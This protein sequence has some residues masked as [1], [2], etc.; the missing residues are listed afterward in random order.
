MREHWLGTWATGLMI[1]SMA[2]VWRV[3]LGWL[4]ATDAPTADSGHRGRPRVAA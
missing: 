1:G 4:G 2:T 3:A